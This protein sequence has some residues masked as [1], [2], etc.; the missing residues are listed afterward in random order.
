MHISKQAS[1][2]K[3]RTTKLERSAKDNS[4]ALGSKWLQS[5]T[6]ID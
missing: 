1:Y 3:P 4:L 6:R 2:E 5:M